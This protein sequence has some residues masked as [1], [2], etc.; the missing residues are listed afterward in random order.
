MEL[1]SKDKL[2]ILI[3]WISGSLIGFMHFN[4]LKIFESIYYGIGW[5]IGAL[6]LGSITHL[7]IKL[8]EILKL[9]EVIDSQ[10]R[11]KRTIRHGLGW[12]IFATLTALILYFN[13]YTI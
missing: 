3:I 2:G 12:T 11:M 6:I 13:N 9:K 7:F 1:N 4:S 8:L 10:G 5:L